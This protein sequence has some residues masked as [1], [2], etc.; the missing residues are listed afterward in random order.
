METYD[1]IFLSEIIIHIFLSYGRFFQ[2]II[3]M[4]IDHHVLSFGR[5]PLGKGTRSMAIWTSARICA[6]CCAGRRKSLEQVSDD[7]IDAGAG[8]DQYQV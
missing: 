5:G 2:K 7:S 3:A 1:S 4:M 6:C 8:F